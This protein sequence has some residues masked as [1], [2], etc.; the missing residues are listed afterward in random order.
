MTKLPYQ[1]VSVLG[2]GLLILSLIGYGNFTR[3]KNHPVSSP[4][5]SINKTIEK[6][7]RCQRCSWID[8]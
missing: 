3:S 1:K 8:E 5:H 6:N 4:D 2:A 7:K